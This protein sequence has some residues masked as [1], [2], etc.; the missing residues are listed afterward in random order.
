[1][2]R[3][4]QNE[5]GMEN[6]QWKWE[7]VCTSHNPSL[8]NIANNRKFTEAMLDAKT[9]LLFVFAVTSNSPNGKFLV[10]TFY[11]FD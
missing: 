9:W 7:Q 11:R 4:K 10:S 1:M 8:I 6:K 3:I 2:E 5:T